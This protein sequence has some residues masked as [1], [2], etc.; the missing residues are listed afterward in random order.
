M[1]APQIDVFSATAAGTN[2]GATATQALSVGIAYVAL[3]ISG[4]TDADSVI[5]IESPAATILWEGAVDVSVDGIGFDFNP[6]IPAPRGGVIIGKI[7]SSTA[8][9]QVTISG[10][11][12]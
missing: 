9:C 7:A 5:T 1:A 6:R 10:S 3:N 11:R 8:D 4:H 2:A 12:K